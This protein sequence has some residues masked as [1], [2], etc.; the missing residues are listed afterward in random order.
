MRLRCHKTVKKLTG[1]L[2]LVVAL[3]LWLISCGFGSCIAVG[4]QLILLSIAY[5][6][7]LFA[8]TIVTCFPQKWDQI[9]KPDPNDTLQLLFDRL[10]SLDLFPITSAHDLIA[11]IT[12]HCAGIFGR[13]R[14]PSHLQFKEIFKSAIGEAV[15]KSLILGIY[16]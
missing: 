14:A 1:R 7:V 16:A 13:A 12:N 15:S 2:C 10:G 3:S 11:V 5:E 4:F 6:L 9:S 8:D